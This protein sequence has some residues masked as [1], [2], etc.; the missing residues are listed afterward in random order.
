MCGKI[1]GKVR[2]REIIAS[3]FLHNLKSCNR[4]IGKSDENLRWNY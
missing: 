3:I 4:I 2:E 1:P